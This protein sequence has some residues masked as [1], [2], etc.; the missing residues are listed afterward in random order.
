ME[1]QLLDQPLT[2]LVKADKWKR[3]AAIIID[4]LIAYIPMV[5]FSVF[6][7]YKL[8]SLAYLVALAYYLLRDALLDGRSIRKKVL[9]LKVV[10]TADGGSIAGDF[11]K[12][13]VRNVSLAI[14]ILNIVDA[15][16][17]LTDKDRLG[18]GWAGTMVVE[19]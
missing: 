16:F 14:P 3:L 10:K 8:W 4:G 11:G 18:D 5:L 17:V 9:K 7:L 2:N 12:S 19:E 6:G 15:I 13:A 1:N